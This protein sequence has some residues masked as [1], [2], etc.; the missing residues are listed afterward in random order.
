[1]LCPL[2]SGSPP[3]PPSPIPMYRSPSGPKA[4]CA[5]VVVRERLVDV[6]EDPLGRRVGLVGRRGRRRVNDE[7]TVF[8]LVS[9]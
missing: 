2:P 5:A 6:E 4:S 1:M 3:D 8:P 9:V 7:T